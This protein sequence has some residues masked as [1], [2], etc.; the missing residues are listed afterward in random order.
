MFGSISIKKRWKIVFLATHPKG[1]KLTKTQ[2]ANYTH[3]ST[4]TVGFW[5]QKYKDTHGVDE[6][7]HPGRPTHFT[8]KTDTIMNEILDKDPEASATKIAA[9]LKRVRE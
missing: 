2:I 9:K 1:P 3:C 5:L 8:S 7:E 6:L 4:K